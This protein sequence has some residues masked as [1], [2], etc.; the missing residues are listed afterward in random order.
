MTEEQALARL[1]ELQRRCEA[2][3]TTAPAGGWPMTESR[4]RVFMSAWEQTA[5]EKQPFAVRALFKCF[6]ALRSA[7]LEQGLEIWHLFPPDPPNA[8]WVS[9]AERSGPPQPPVAPP[10]ASFSS[11]PEPQTPKEDLW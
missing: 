5:P 9:Q 8:P 3:E 1:K 10:P 2:E 6:E 11:E 4:I 7:E